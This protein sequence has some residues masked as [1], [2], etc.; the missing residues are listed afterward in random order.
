MWPKKD[1]KVLGK[2]NTPLLSIIEE[3]FV[4]FHIHAWKE[5]A[6]YTCQI[7]IMMLHHLLLHSTQLPD[8]NNYTHYS[9]SPMCAIPKMQP[10]RRQKLNFL[11]SPNTAN[12]TGK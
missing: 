5:D 11:V 10:S 6:S 12:F 3:Q 2:E 4:N 8:T 9:E 1:M 7:K